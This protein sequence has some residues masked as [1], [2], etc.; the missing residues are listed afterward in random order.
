M[1]KK[2]LV[3]FSMGLDS[4]TLAYHYKAQGFDVTLAYFDDGPWNSPKSQFFEADREVCETDF[5]A[6]ESDFYANWHAQHAGFKVTKL[7]YPELNSIHAQCPADNT[8][9]EFAESIGLHY[10]VGFKMIMAML[11]MSHGAAFGYDEVVFG[12]LVS[13]DAYFDETPEP[14]TKLSELMTFTYG[15]RIK[16][17]KLSNPYQDWGFDKQEV[18]ELALKCG[19]P[20]EMTYSCRRMPAIRGEDQRFI[21]CGE[22]ENCIKRKAAFE[23]FGKVDPAPYDNK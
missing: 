12:H 16:L 18:L 11:L 19:V 2:V 10:W 20:L 6:V 14:F 9:A 13:D 8:K 15:N 5:M 7:R 17:P 23:K 1:K 4:T 22:C 3:C 21:S